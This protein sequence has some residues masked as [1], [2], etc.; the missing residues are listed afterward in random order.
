MAAVAKTIARIALVDPLKAIVKSYIAN[1]AIDAGEAV[2]IVAASG[3]AQLCDANAAGTEQ[4]R[5]IALNS[6]GAGQAVDVV[7]DGEVY[8]FTLAGNYDT[9]VYVGDTAGGLDT[10]AST[11]KTVAAGRVVPLADKDQTKVL[12]VFVQRE[13]DW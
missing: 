6:V 1:E 2:S 13:V 3:N 4:F 10:V 9:L 11:T 7:E 5:G 8:G 12:R